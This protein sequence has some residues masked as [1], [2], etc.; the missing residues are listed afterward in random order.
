MRKPNFE[1]L[2]TDI[3]LAYKQEIDKVLKARSREEQRKKKLAVRIRKMAEAEGMSLKEVLTAGAAKAKAGGKRQKT[4]AKR[5]T[6][7]PKYRNPADRKQTWT[8]RGRKPAWVAA[9]LKG[10][11]K[12]EDLAIN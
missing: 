8:G 5:G 9:H 1:K 12:L 7:K 11:G 10:G 3:L 2:N 6:V 4:A